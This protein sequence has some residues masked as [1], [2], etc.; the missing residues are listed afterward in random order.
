ML[1]LE[2][3]H[4]AYSPEM[5]LLCLLPLEPGGAPL[6]TLASDL[7]LPDQ[8][9]VRALMKKL[10]KCGIKLTTWRSPRGGYLVAV[11]PGSWAQA[12]A[13]GSSYLD[14]LTGAA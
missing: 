12:Q 10:G 4:P 1:L 8:S 13:M 2:T 6:K 3:K 11:S 9:N 7:C 14:Q 5:E